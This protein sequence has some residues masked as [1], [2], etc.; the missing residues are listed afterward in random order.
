MVQAKREEVQDAKAAAKSGS[1][2][3][4]DADSTPETQPATAAPSKAADENATQKLDDFDLQDPEQQAAAGKLQGQWRM[5]ESRKAVQAKRDAARQ[6]GEREGQELHGAQHSIERVETVATRPSTVAGGTRS[7][8][9]S[10][11]AAEAQ[12]RPRT[13]DFVSTAGLDNEFGEQ[14][15]DEDM[16]RSGDDD[17]DDSEG[18]L[19]EDF[20]DAKSGKTYYHNTHT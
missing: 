9:P 2:V 13:V 14:Y 6:K 4:T 1:M 7:H 12:G 3:G 10:D 17:S 20:V 16:G 18:P 19:W 11:E 15:S 5:K 8:H